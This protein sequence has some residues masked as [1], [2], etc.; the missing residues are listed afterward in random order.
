VVTEG[1][2]IDEGAGPWAV[3]EP[4]CRELAARYWDK[5]AGDVPGVQ[6]AR[7]LYRSIGVDPTKIRPSSEALL[8][9]VLKGKPLY[10]INSLVD[11][12]NYCSLSYLLPIGLYDLDRLEGESIILRR[13]L[14]G[15][16][17]EG[18]RK[19]TVNLEGRYAMFDTLG[20]FGSPTSD[21]ARA[22]I[23]AWTT[24][25]LTVIFAPYEM[26]LK[27]LKDHARFTAQQIVRFGGGNPEARL[28]EVQGLKP[29]D[30]PL[31]LLILFQTRLKKLK[32]LLFRGA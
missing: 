30:K 14:P 28:G 7:R 12:I 17:F 1:L 26:D 6:A 3:F 15:E 4:F 13:G 5:T 18:I 8:R 9:R 27:T 2:E 25:S 20:P 10:R 19:D 23:S 22:S 21:S 29:I 16:C 32:N 31:G 11:T 24:R